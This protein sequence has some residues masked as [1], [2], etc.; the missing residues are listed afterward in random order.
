MN[1]NFSPH[2]NR[3]I[4]PLKY[5]IVHA[6]LK[7]FPQLQ[8][9]LNGG[10]TDLEAAEQHLKDNPTLHGVMI[11]R[12]IINNPYGWNTVDS[13]IYGKADPGLFGNK[14]FDTFLCSYLLLFASF[15]W[16]YFLR[17]IMLHNLHRY[18]QKADVGAVRTVRQ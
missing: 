8:F 15:L 3:S 16:V 2:D 13:R 7:D 18:Q 4:P 6:L 10:V 5:D 12:G 1:A 11:G 9:T 17:T 14:M